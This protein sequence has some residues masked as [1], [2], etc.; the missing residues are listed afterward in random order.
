MSALRSSFNENIN[1]TAQEWDELIG[2]KLDS[3]SLEGQMI[4]FLARVPLLMR[5]GRFVLGRQSRMQAPSPSIEHEARVLH[6]DFL[7]VLAG[8]RE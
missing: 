6:H 7:P 4:D 8:L 2:A 3:A 5:R 1:L